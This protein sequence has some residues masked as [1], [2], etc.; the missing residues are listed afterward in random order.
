M[1]RKSCIFY[2]GGVLENLKR[3]LRLFLVFF[4]IGLFTFGGGYAMIAV[5]ERE[6]VEKKGW[7]NHEEFLDIIGI[8]ESSPG[9]LAVNS[10]TFIGYKYGKFFGALFAT[11][12]V[13]LPSFI[14]IFA[15]S[16]FFEQF[17]ALE[18][19]GYAFRG[20]Q[21]CVA[22]LILSAG[23]KM[24]KHLKRNAFNVIMVSLT[25]ATMI[26]LELFA[27]NFSTIFLIL[28]GGAIG[29]SVYLIG[30][31]KLRNKERNGGKE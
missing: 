5:M 17:L 29:L 18:Y 27:P 20:I 3:I 6:F 24:L 21:A 28:I 2:K 26:L 13:V 30:Y 16:F 23:V 7:I 1:Q 14:I 10:A 19:V 4:K 31:F 11:L 15:I 22:F 9:P 12:G 25:V 8:A